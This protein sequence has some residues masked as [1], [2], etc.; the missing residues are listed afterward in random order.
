MGWE[1]PPVGVAEWMGIDDD[2][3]GPDF[4]AKLAD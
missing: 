4:A 3:L 2:Y 1:P